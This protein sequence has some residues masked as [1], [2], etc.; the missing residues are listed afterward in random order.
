MTKYS[1][2]K[3]DLSVEGFFSEPTLNLLRANSDLLGVVT[4]CLSQFCPIRGADIRIDQDSNPLG[5]ANVAFELHP[6]NGVARVS[7]DRAQIAFFSPHSL[8]IDLIS[9]LSSA[10]F[11]SVGEVVSPNSY[12]HYLVQFSFHAELEN[13]SATDHTRQFVSAPSVDSDSAIGNSVTY[14]FGK[15]NLRLHSSVTLDMSGEFSDCVFVRIA[16]GI[17]ANEISDVGLKTTVIDHGNSLLTLVGLEAE[18]LT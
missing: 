2:R 8:E 12:G 14:Y 5:N 9:R 7:I 18:W 16:I 6:F 13:V 17:D 15:H 11:D 3:S 4:P 1:I 10:Y